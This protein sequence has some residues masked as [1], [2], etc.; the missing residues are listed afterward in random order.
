[1]IEDFK[2]P[3][4]YEYNRNINDVLIDQLLDGLKNKNI[5][6][7]NILSINEQK[8]LINLIKEIEVFKGNLITLILVLLQNFS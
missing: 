6:K 3:N 4:Y 1:M 2:H 5:V 8:D 7:S